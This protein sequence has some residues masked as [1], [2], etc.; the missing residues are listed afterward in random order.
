M[1]RIDQRTVLERFLCLRDASLDFAKNPT[2]RRAALDLH[3]AAIRYA[4]AIRK[5]SRRGRAQ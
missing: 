5:V 3:E 2:W 4:D 1:T